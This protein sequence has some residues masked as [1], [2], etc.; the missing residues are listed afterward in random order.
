[1]YRKEDQKQSSTIYTVSSLTTEIKSLLEDKYPFVWIQGEISNLGRPSSGHIYFTLKDSRSQIAAIVFR[2]LAHHLKFQLENGLQITGMARLTLYEPRGAYQLVFEFIEPKGT[3]ALQLAFE[4]LRNRLAQEGLF[5]EKFK[6]KLPFIPERI[7]VITSP[8]GAVIHDIINII[9]RRF[10]DVVL[11]IVPVKVQGDQAEHEISS[12]LAMLNSR[13]LSDLI[14]IARG[15]GS[16]EDLAAFNSEIL[17]RAVF[18]SEIPVV[19]AVG[20]ET[21][22]TICDFVSDLRAP[23]PSAAAELVVP[24][25][26][27]LV[28]DVE[29]LKT[30][31]IRRMGVILEKKKFHLLKISEKLIDPRRRIIDLRLKLDD[32]TQRLVRAFHKTIDHKRA[33]ISWRSEKLT[34][35]SPLKKNA[36]LKNR[37]ARLNDELLIRMGA[38]IQKK[39]IRFGEARAKIDA[40]NPLAILKRGYSVTRTVPDA[41]VVTDTRCV[42]QN[43][44]LE[45]ILAHGS[46]RVGVKGIIKNGEKKF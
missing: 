13:R 15:G 20:H 12:A 6:K 4:Q 9:D 35:L 45:I 17:A 37:L 8:T 36:E 39:R 42:S 28:S 10:P 22:Y 18:S 1:L 24:V 33:Y 23:T 21:D 30:A 43:Q 3:G 14:I 32:Y 29:R 41:N 46:L 11:E 31:L 25:K 2:N 26:N 34:L 19:S 44:D 27:D 40:L 16:L 7:S 5:D 38:I